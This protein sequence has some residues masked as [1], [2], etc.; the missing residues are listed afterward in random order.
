MGLIYA[1]GN[2]MSKAFM[3][4]TT[5]R[6]GKVLAE[7]IDGSVYEAMAIAIREH[8]P[9]TQPE[10]IFPFDILLIGGDDIVM[11]LQP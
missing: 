3:N 9:I 2:G 11:E 1:D 5:L 10:N 7:I 4:L 8:L 6:E